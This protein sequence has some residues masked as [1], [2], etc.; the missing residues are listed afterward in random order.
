MCPK[1]FGYVATLDSCVRSIVCRHALLTKNC[2]LIKATPASGAKS[3]VS[4][5]PHP[6]RNKRS[7]RC[8]LG[9]DPKITSRNLVQPPKTATSI[10]DKFTR[11]ER[12]IAVRLTHPPMNSVGSLS[13]PP[14]GDKSIDL[15]FIQE[16]KKN[17]PIDTTFDSGVRSIYSR[18]EHWNKN[19]DPM[20][21]TVDR[22]DRSKVDVRPLHP[23]KKFFEMCAAP[24]NTSN[25][26]I[27]LVSLGQWLSS[28][29]GIDREAIVVLVVVVSLVSVVG[30]GGNIPAT[31]DVH[32]SKARGEL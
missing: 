2:F 10:R 27:S 5:E 11:G 28:P 21:V 8:S 30:G 17:G 9:S 14:R 13:S 29:E 23:T 19:A 24:W 16:C 4:N 26:K 15:I 22:G 25:P 6:L 31:S 18:E 7:I 20:D 32:L 1:K 3:K 12:S